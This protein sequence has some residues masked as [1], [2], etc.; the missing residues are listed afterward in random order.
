MIWPSA[1]PKPKQ[2]AFE[3]VWNQILA[4]RE[5]GW[6][7]VD[8]GADGGVDGVVPEVIEAIATDINIPCIAFNKRRSRVV[9][10]LKNAVCHS[11]MAVGV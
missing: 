5:I 3:E 6:S 4:G 8:L 7:V 11:E 9:C 2:K 1:P 10:S